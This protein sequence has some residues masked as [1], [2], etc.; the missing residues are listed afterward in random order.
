MLFIKT[1]GILKMPATF[2]FIIIDNKIK[3]PL[4]YLSGLNLANVN[5]LVLTFLT[6]DHFV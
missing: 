4:I 3:R 6:F 2:L 1:A 5:Y